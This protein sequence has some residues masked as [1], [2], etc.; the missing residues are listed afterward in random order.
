MNTRTYYL[1]DIDCKVSL[2]NDFK[3]HTFYILK[4][5]LAQKWEK[6]KDKEKFL[7]KVRNDK[8]I[9]C[10]INTESQNI[11]Y[12]SAQ[13][14]EFFI[15]N[16]II[17]FLHIELNYKCNLKCKH[18]F[19]PKNMDEYFI[20]FAQAKKIIDEAYKSDIYGIALTGGECTINKDFLKIAK[21]VREKRMPLSIL[22]NG[23]KLYDDENLYNEL[24]SINPSNFQIS[25][26]SMQSE[27]HDN[28]TGVKGSH[29]KTLS[30]I[31][32]LREKNINVYIACPQISYNI[33][34]Y[35]EVKKYADEIGAGFSTGC[36]FIYNKNNK[37]L[38]AKCRLEDI[39]KFYCDTLA[40][41]ENRNFKKSDGRICNAGKNTLSICPNL[42]ITPC[43]GFNYVLGNYNT[44]SL[45]KLQEKVLPKFRE[46]F[47]KSNLKECF[48]HEYCKYCRYC[49]IQSTHE[50]GF[51]KKSPILCED[52]RAYYNAYLKH[53]QLQK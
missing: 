7:L 47:I 23:Q 38:N 27:E 53:K 52:A 29:H 21:Y 28:I 10:A 1:K 3:N 40:M 43:T 22:T 44:T 17:S 25:V 16:N 19:N 31:K 51:L 50:T 48:K 34:S 26:Y 11:K 8:D 35:K 41:N 20:S 12:F 4:N 45:K 18:C 24:L 33:G 39:E 30:I 32:R 37:N 13:L 46:K 9:K 5:E 14:F 2:I 6:A 15:E 49:S 36:N 42:D